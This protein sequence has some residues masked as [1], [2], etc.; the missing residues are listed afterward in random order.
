VR[1]VPPHK[2]ALESFFDCRI[3]LAELDRLTAKDC[4]TLLMHVYEVHPRKDKRGINLISDALAIRMP[5]S[6]E[7]S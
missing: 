2:I 5:R 3:A 7:G 4:A 6:Y 1:Q